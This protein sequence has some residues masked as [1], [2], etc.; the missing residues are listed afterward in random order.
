MIV[1][2]GRAYLCRDGIV[3]WVVTRRKTDSGFCVTWDTR[4]PNDPAY[5]NAPQ[6]DD[7]LARMAEGASGTMAINLFHAEIVEDV[8]PDS[9]S[10]RFN[11]HA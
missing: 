4:N 10:T 1:K 8:T 5:W 6:H 3:R 9:N 2:S 11:E 7:L